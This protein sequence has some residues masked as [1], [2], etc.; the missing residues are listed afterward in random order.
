MILKIFILKILKGD[1]I[2]EFAIFA[3]LSVVFLTLF[4]IV[5]VKK[6]A[7]PLALIFKTLASLSFV[8]GS[9]Y[10]S[11]KIGLTLPNMIITFGLIF[12]LIGDIVLDL[13]VAY[14]EHNK[15]YLNSGMIS[16]S[17]ST[18][19]YLVA[20]VLLWNPLS[21]F[22]FMSI[23]SLVIGVLFATIV[24]LLA[25]PLKLDFT[26]HKILTFIYSTLLTTTAV[27]SLAV[28]IYIPGFF[29]FASGIVLVLLSDLVLSMMYFGG[30]QSN[31]ILCIINHVLYYL[32]EILV[33]AFLFFQLGA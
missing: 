4:L 1:K 23:G 19:L 22:L 8:F 14:P 9:I 2:M 20:V 21:K 6:G 26:G 32:G 16:F 18:V 5:R 29:I 15:I 3:S 28:G 33:M 25:K 30:K 12:A 13:K 10:A 31:S 24:F 17:L 11:F 7:G 27:L